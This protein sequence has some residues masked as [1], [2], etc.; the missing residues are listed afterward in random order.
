MLYLKKTLKN[1]AKYIHEHLSTKICSND[2]YSFYD[3]F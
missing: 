2:S 1:Y 3:S